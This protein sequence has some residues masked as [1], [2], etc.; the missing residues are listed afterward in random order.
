[1]IQYKKWVLLW[2]WFVLNTVITINVVW[3]VILPYQLL[4]KIFFEFLILEKL[5]RIIVR[6]SWSA[7]KRGFYG[8][9]KK[10]YWTQGVE[11][12]TEFADPNFR[13]PLKFSDF[14]SE[15]KVRKLF[16]ISVK[17]APSEMALITLRAPPPLKRHT[18]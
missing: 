11:T 14:Y 9:K 12:C 10:Y 15:K 6:C 5:L 13:R 2:E 7:T 17:N 16:I 1:M 18:T 8:I 3:L 4:V